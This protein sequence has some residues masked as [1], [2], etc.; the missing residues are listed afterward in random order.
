MSKR[1]TIITIEDRNR[2]SVERLAEDN[3]ISVYYTA[4]GG[5]CIHVEQEVIDEVIDE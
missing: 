4:T 2:V 1:E 3:I 5:L